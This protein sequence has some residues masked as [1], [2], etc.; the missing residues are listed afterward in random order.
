MV[1]FEW[2]ERTNWRFFLVKFC[3]SSEP[4]FNLQIQSFSNKIMISSID[5]SD[6]F[7]RTCYWFRSLEHV[8]QRA[9]LCDRSFRL[10]TSIDSLLTD[11]HE[12]VTA[13]VAADFLGWISLGLS[14]SVSFASFQ[15]RSSTGC[16][17]EIHREH[18]CHLHLP[19]AS[20]NGHWIESGN[21]RDCR[22]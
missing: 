14:W 15:F 17:S 1:H 22:E 21:A 10:S 2:S 16:P 6:L 11:V 9:V 12:R 19:I 4:I 20:D 8:D 7:Q 3:L 13:I 18:I 5:K